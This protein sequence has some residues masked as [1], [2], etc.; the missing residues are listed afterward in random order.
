[1]QVFDKDKFLLLKDKP[2]RWYELSI[3]K[4]NKSK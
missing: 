3:K 2:I 4:Q 1:M